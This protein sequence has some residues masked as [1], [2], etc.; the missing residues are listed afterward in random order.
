MD[1][2]LNS[3]D[4]G[5]EL[6]PPSLEPWT[7]VPGK[8]TVAVMMSGGVD[9]SVTAH[10]LKQAGFDVLGVTMKVPVACD[11]G[12]R[13]CC[14]ADAAL[15]CHELGISHYFVDVTGAFKKLIIE[16]FQN[17]YEKGHTPNPCVDC[18][19]FLKYSLLWDLVEKTF[20]I[21]QFA[22][23]HYARVIHTDTGTVLARAKDTSKDQS[24]FIYG[25]TK[26]KLANYHLPLGEYSKPQ[27]RDIASNL[28]LTVAEKPESM[29]LCFAGEGDYRRAL[30]GSSVTDPG[31][32]LDIDGNIIGEHK[33]IVNY[34]IGQRR[35]LGVAGGVPLYV[36]KIDPKNNTVT[37]GT[38]EDACEKTISA[39]TLNILLHDAYKPGSSVFAKIRSTGDP[40][41][42][43]LLKANPNSMTI[44]FQSPQ[45]AP[46]PGQRL[47]IYNDKNHVIAG[48]VI[49]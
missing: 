15:V 23:G 43:K 8:T 35:G 31:R 22:T 13:G 10:L 42:C 12:K 21:H 4:Y 46:T 33:G 29:E 17:S 48:A 47:V 39:D 18:N 19:S 14:G 5:I 9:S 34:T 20:D 44:E 36:A 24:Y 45:F 27:I 1:K 3:E 7:P 49:L 28:G 11:T 38:R 2:S 37:L 40:H 32:I 25:I 30:T 6:L 26:Q 16:P 41:P